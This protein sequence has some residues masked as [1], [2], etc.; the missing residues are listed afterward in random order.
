MYD[1]R[2]GIHVIS[3]DVLVAPRAI[4]T[5]SSSKSALRRPRSDDV[6]ARRP[7][8]RDARDRAGR[9]SGAVCGGRAG[10][11]EPRSGNGSSGPR[12]SGG[13]GQRVPRRR[14]TRTRV[15]AIRAVFVFPACGRSPGRPAS[16]DGPG[17]LRIPPHR[18]QPWVEQ[19]LF[20]AAIGEARDKER[21]RSRPSR[22]ATARALPSAERFLVHRAVFPRDF[23]ADFGFQT[24]RS[25][26][27]IELA[28]LT[29][30]GLQPVAEG[31]RA[32][33]C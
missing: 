19:S 14:R 22:T 20:L 16:S 10:E 5:S 27:R 17:D 21:E 6:T 32:G 2:D 33:R 31:T 26:G 28:R 23:L 12:R 30:G 24:V 13:L 7:H 8:R 1:R 25:A 29:S 3:T 18:L 15:D 11:Q 4:P 9:L